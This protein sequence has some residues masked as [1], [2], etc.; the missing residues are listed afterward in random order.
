MK[1][2]H[3]IL[4]FPKT[5]NKTRETNLEIIYNSKN[6]MT[7]LKFEI[8]IKKSKNKSTHEIWMD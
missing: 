8:E 6:Q 4:C 1:S 3:R 7:E 5:K 2:S